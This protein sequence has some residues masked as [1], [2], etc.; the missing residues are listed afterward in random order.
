ML[1]TPDASAL[2]RK[3]VTWELPVPEALNSM[4]CPGAAERGQQYPSMSVLEPSDVTLPPVPRTEN[5]KL[6]CWAL[7]KV[8]ETDQMNINPEAFSVFMIVTPMQITSF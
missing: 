7:S 4:T 2:W 6:N 5:S 1:V 3:N 8:T